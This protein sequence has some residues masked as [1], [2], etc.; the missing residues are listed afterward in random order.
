MLVKL[1]FSYHIIAFIATTDGK[2]FIS[3]SR[4]GAISHIKGQGED[5]AKELLDNGGAPILKDLLG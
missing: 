2:E 5:I 4:S 3:R 1:F